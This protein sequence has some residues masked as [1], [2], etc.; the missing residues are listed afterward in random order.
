MFDNF[1]LDLA[2]K[3][4]LSAGVTEIRIHSNDPGN[5]GANQITYTG[6]PNND[7]VDVAANGW[8]YG[9]DGTASPI[10][11][12]SFPATPAGFTGANCSWVTGWRGN[13]RLFKTRIQVSDGSGGFQ[14]G[15][16]AIAA[17]RIPRFTPANLRLSIPAS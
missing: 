5:A 15:S 8:R 2:I 7:G 4:V 13:S 11:N 6:L 10:A 12:V 3:G 1:A 17:E 14:N 9:A 16:I